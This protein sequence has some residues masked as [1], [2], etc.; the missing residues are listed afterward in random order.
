VSFLKQV[1]NPV[2]YVENLEDINCK[3]RKLRRENKELKYSYFIKAH[4]TFSMRKG[5]KSCT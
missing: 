4:F 3:T 5:Y 2:G 1:F